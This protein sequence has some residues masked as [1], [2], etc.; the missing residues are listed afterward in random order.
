MYRFAT[1]AAFALT[2]L[3][4]SSAWA[5]FEGPSGGP[6]LGDPSDPFDAFDAII[7]VGVG[8]N[9]N[10]QLWADM[11]S[12]PELHDTRE[13]TFLTTTLD[14]TF[15][16]RINPLFT[17]GAAL[18]VDGTATLNEIPVALQPQYGE[19]NNYDLIAINPSLFANVMLG[20]VDVRFVYSF[21]FEDAAEERSIGLYGHQIGI[22]LSKDVSATWRI[23]AGAS[24]AW[25][26]FGIVFADPVND[27]DGTLHLSSAPAPTIISAAAIRC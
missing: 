4:A 2:S 19:F 21:R 27:R 14:A 9:D 1:A 10:I 5:G 20:G 24:H 3:A 15:R 6:N 8:R 23:R 26:D 13:S 12:L 25:N 16:H 18:R 11:S 17:V 7:R 22:E